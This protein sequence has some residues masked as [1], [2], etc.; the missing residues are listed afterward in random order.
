M[1]N[2]GQIY[3]RSDL[4]DR[5]GGQRQG[6]ISTPANHKIILIFTGQNG[7]E[8]GYKDEWQPGSLFHYTGEGQIG[9]M[10]F[11]RGNSAIRDHI[12]NGKELHLFSAKGKGQVQY[13]GQFEFRN[14]H[15]RNGTDTNGNPR[16]MIVFEL[17]PLN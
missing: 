2:S 17:A 11:V 12:Q 14:Y 8:H 10:A 5:F 13:E 15:Y 4:H 7:A 3:K 16:R 6:G 1:F 9:D